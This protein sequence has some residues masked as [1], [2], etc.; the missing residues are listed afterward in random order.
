MSFK[1]KTLFC[2]KLIKFISCEHTFVCL[3][4]TY[5]SKKGGY[6][7]GSRIFLREIL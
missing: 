2:E 5:L 4:I 6:I 3:K 7:L 1:I